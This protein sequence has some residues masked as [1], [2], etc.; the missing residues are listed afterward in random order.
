MP[1]VRRASYSLERCAY[2][3]IV[4]FRCAGIVFRRAA[5]GLSGLSCGL[6]TLR[7]LRGLRPTTLAVALGLARRVAIA[8]VLRAEDAGRNPRVVLRDTQL[9]RAACDLTGTRRLA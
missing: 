7:K 5:I 9:R 4:V 3:G 2:A 6:E 1:L 8:G